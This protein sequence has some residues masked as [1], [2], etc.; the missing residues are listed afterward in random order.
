MRN[1]KK[2]QKRSLK[3]KAAKIK[4]HELKERIQKL[5]IE[6]LSGFEWRY[7]LRIVINFCQERQAKS[8]L[9]KVTNDDDYKPAPKLCFL[10]RQYIYLWCGEGKSQSE[11]ARRLKRHKSTIC[12][13]LRRNW[14]AVQKYRNYPYEAAKFAQDLSDRRRSVSRI[15]P[16]IKDLEI[17]IAIEEALQESLSPQEISIR[18]YLELGRSVS[19]ETIYQWIFIERRDLICFLRHGGKK[20]HKR[21]SERRRRALRQPASPKI[22]I[23]KRSKAANNR[24][25]FGHWEFDTIVS[26][27]S[28]EC[29]LVIQER[30]SRYFFVVKL[31]ACTAEEVA[32]A[33][34][35]CLKPFDSTWLKSLTCDNGPENSCQD[36]LKVALGVP[37]YYCHPYCS[38]ERGGVENRNGSLRSYYPKKTDFRFVSAEHL[39]MTR[40]KLLRKPMKCLEYFTPLEVFTGEFQPMFRKAA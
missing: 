20:Y 5:T 25:E 15:K 26:K 1:E 30:V 22:S 36:E 4:K 7:I 39:E 9:A 27:Q 24:L 12:N 37:V 8:F 10:E 18:I 2:T 34:I 13:E 38:S 28:T 3:R 29:L 31:K 14:Q 17:R 11:I 23:D 6:L 40:Q 35:E 33:V 21:K 19:H 32:K 16:R